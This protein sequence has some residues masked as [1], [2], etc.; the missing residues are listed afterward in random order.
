MAMN[1]RLLRPLATFNPLAPL[2]I[3]SLQLWLDSSDAS[4]LTLNGSA[5]SQTVSEWRD[6][7]IGSDRKAAQAT[8]ANQPDYKPAGINGKPT[9]FFKAS[10][11]MD[12]SG[13]SFA[14][15][16]P[17]SYFHIWRT[18]AAS[19]TGTVFDNDTG[20]RHILSSNSSTFVTNV[21]GGSSFVTTS[22]GRT[23]EEVVAA[24]HILSGAASQAAVNT[25]TL[26]T[27]P[28]SPGTANSPT[29]YKVGA[30]TNDAQSL[31][32]DMAEFMVFNAAITAANVQALM[33]Y[34]RG[35]WGVAV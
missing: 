17:V 31:L 16:Q 11:W 10:S 5:P 13:T 2:A 14:F 29:H 12:T 6:R 15:A 33:D 18:P 35:K 30:F 20:A 23:A 26:A 27:L 28:S 34:A 22:T 19:L 3:P 7:R 21:F 8:G 4:T 24:A 9:V 32:G 25:R 1:P